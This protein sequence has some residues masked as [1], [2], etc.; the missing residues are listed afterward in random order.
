MG[1]YLSA[2]V[3]T[4]ELD[5]SN[6]I[7]AVDTS[8]G[9][10]VGYSTRGP[11][12]RHLVTNTKNFVDLYGEP[13]PGNWLHYAALGFLQRANKLY[14]S[15]VVNGAR[16]AGAEIK[17]DT[18]EFDNES[19]VSGPLDP[20]GYSFGIDGL[21]GI[22]A[23]NQGVWGNNLVVRIT[24]STDP[25]TPWSSASSSSS[26]TSSS[27][28]S[29]S[30]VSSSKSSVSS[31]SSSKSS[32]SSVNSSVSSTSSVSSS[33]QSS[34][35]AVS[36]TSSI[37]SSDSSASSSTTAGLF[38]FD[39]EVY[40]LNTDTDTY[41]QRLSQTVSRR[42]QKDGYGRDQ[43]IGDVFGTDAD[44]Q[45][46]NNYIRVIDNTLVPSTV[47]PK[48][49]LIN[50]SMAGGDD[51]TAITSG[52]VIQSWDD[53]FANPEEVTV[54]ILMSA[55][56]T[57]AAILQNIDTICQSRKDC[58]GVLD[59][60]YGE[61]EADDLVTWKKNTL[62]IDSS[63]SAIYS[64][65]LQVYDQYN[66]K[67]VFIP[68][69]GYAGGVY[70]YTDYTTEPWFAPAGM[71][72]GVLSVQ[73]LEKVW[74][75]GERDVLYSNNINPIKRSSISGVAV[76]WGQKTLQSKPSALD[77]IN[78]RRLLIVMEKSVATALEYWDFEPND[79]FTR[80]FI[81]D[82]IDS[83]LRD[84]RSRRGLYDYRIVCDETNNTGAI[85]DRN[86]LHVDIYIKPVRAA[87][88]I[89][90]QVVITRTDASFDEV[91]GAVTPTS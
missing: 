15:R 73:D 37:S 11:V 25:G 75:L 79:K 16:F 8:I 77:R 51:G 28:S 1:F 14:V 24:N 42:D 58:I 69:S 57:E 49:Q 44:G 12:G 27:T 31:E 78:V 20:A 32:V 30:S 61:D 66:D 9:G 2:G 87:E 45:S 64:P 4:Q 86:E 48:E 80:I 82:M 76:V 52:Q 6:I 39:I 72:R 19:I 84:I 47:A 33:V 46:T 21:L 34:S 63:Y 83:F 88:F 81:T 22:F 54:N 43:Y 67:K 60:P 74:D 85:I 36:S 3:Y 89:Q 62:K 38:E 56:Y 65:W 26:T 71:N 7:P 50:L 10:M 29:A 17:K 55:G 70:A 91:I 40:E 5:L 13:A 90:L 68:P 35:S 53:N 59:V 18:S 41:E 23:S